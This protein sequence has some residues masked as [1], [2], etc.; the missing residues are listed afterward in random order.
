MKAHEALQAIEDGLAWASG[1]VVIVDVLDFGA[2]LPQEFVS[3]L[4]G[5][6]MVLAVNKV[7]LLPAQTPL[8]EVQIWVR[9]RLKEYAL[10]KVEVCLVSAVN[11]YGFPKLAD[12]VEVWASAFC[13][14]G[15]PM[16]ANPA[17]WNA[18]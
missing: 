12:A 7:D 14:W 5:R 15:L 18:F 17:F 16:W 8:E 13:L 9:R 11:G 1:V 6:N 2:G 10:P 4:R 3:L